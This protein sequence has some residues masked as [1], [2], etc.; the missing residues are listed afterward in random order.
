MA[1]IPV[2]AYS[3]PKI[4]RAMLGTRK[5]NTTDIETD[6]ISKPLEIV[7]IPPPKSP[8]VSPSPTAT[9]AKS[10]FAVTAP[11]PAK[12]M[13]LAPPPVTP[14]TPIAKFETKEFKSG[15]LLESVKPY[16]TPPLARKVM[17]IRSISVQQPGPTTGATK[18]LHKFSGNR[19]GADLL[20]DET[21]N[22]QFPSSDLALSSGAGDF[23]RNRFISS[24]Q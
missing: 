12:K 7:T 13:L 1:S 2:H 17:Q 10:M 14:P 3:S 15:S 19:M 22:F 4:R 8:I 11:E 5:G 23:R 6:K 9:V 18:G 21:M 20:S 16:F 24:D